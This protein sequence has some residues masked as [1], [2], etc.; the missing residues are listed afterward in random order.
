MAGDTRQADGAEKL[1]ALLA[2]L[3]AD[4]AQAAE[5]SEERD[6]AAW[7]DLLQVLRRMSFFVPG[8]QDEREEAVQA[9]CVKLQNPGTLAQVLEAQWPGAY[10]RRIVRNEV[11]N[12]FRR[13]SRAVSLVT[14]EQRKVVS[15][16]VSEGL[17]RA[18]SDVAASEEALRS[19]LKG[20]SRQQQELFSARYIEGNSL[21]TI[22]T[23]W[24]ISKGAVTS[25]IHR[26][27]KDLK[28]RATGRA[29]KIGRATRPKL[30]VER[31]RAAWDAWRANGRTWHA[32]SKSAGIRHST[33]SRILT[34]G[35]TKT[36]RAGTLKRLS[37]ALRVPSEWLTGQRPDLPH[38]PEWPYSDRKRKGP[39]RWEKPT[40][41]DVQ[42]SWLL[43]S[44]EDAI[45]RD[46]EEWYGADARN[47]YDAWGHRVID[48][49]AHVC[50]LNLWR[51]ATL[52]TDYG[53]GKDDLLVLR[54]LEHLL[55]PWLEGKANLKADL[56]GEVFQAL[57]AEDAGFDFLPE[58]K[59][60]E[61][62]DASLTALKRYEQAYY[63]S[64]G[65]E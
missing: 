54:W 38:V 63:N 27:V 9:A 19:A 52:F 2:R 12:V 3:A 47:A 15:E 45:K 4:Q 53:S 18:D 25:R 24:G 59:Q 55:A 10:L 40:A 29:A 32:L 39:S 8:D 33:I 17:G 43:Q 36:V 62:R 7:R 28:G 20:L 57:L 48:V 26:I 30:S 64:L 11:I 1:R 61:V 34:S 23:K 21:E 37:Q 44:V 5:G 56:V 60:A 22:A 41:R 6:E 35:R 42:W 65:P 50:D 58:D 14:G 16:A 13:K 51:R 31:L 49:I 46:L